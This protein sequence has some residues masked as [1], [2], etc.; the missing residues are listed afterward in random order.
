MNAIINQIPKGINKTLKPDRF[1]VGSSGFKQ[2][3]LIRVLAKTH[4]L[5]QSDRKDTEKM[6]KSEMGQDESNKGS[7]FKRPES[8]TS[9]NKMRMGGK[10]LSL[11][12]FANAK[13]KTDYNPALISMYKFCV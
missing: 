11:E 3:V 12:A 5:S 9:K 7:R 13:S 1:S 4:S 8:M 6:K 10:G 2:L